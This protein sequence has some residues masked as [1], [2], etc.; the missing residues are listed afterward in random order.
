MGIASTILK[1]GWKYARVLPR[2]AF[3]DGYGVISHART[4][5]AGGTWKTLRHSATAS[6]AGWNALKA[7]IAATA[8]RPSRIA[9][10]WKSG[11]LS[12]ARTIL[13]SGGQISTLAKLK[14]GLKG[15]AKTAGTAIKTAWTTGSTAAA[16]G[17]YLS[18]LGKFGKFL[19]GL[20][21]VLKPLCKMPVLASIIT[22]GL[23]MP[24]I[25]RAF[26]DGGFVEGIKQ[27]GKSGA[28]I[29]IAT[30]VGALGTVV[31]GPVGGIV[32]YVAGEALSSWIFGK[33]YNEL[34]PKAE[35]TQAQGDQNAQD[36]ELNGTMPA[37]ADTQAERDRLREENEAQETDNE[38]ENCNPDSSESAKSETAQPTQDQ[39]GLPER[40]EAPTDTTTFYSPMQP[41]YTP[42]YNS[43]PFGFDAG[44]NI[45]Q[46]FPMGYTFQYQ[47]N[48][49][50][51]MM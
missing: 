36:A 26:S 44:T 9:A 27:L 40:L 35:E 12:E 19:G 6:K 42:S 21:G 11:V 10:A 15:L 51:M 16:T 46:R 30:A 37:D 18:K 3:G 25:C 17:K 33:S 22:L 4:T 8:A 2:Y 48:G 41:S 1:T 13:R 24:D 43:N 39:S 14:G 7:D 31:G 49:F 50:G 38:N 34:H 20:G 45:F 32:G 29:T 47:G 5:A 23:E 28:K